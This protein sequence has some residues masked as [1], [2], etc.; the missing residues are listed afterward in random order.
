MTDDFEREADHR[1]ITLETKVAFQEKMVSDL[2]EVI[3]QQERNIGELRRQLTTLQEQV[4]SLLG[5]G[6]PG[7]EKPPHY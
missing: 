3:I 1:F 5:E 4:H 7:I 2:N 6:Q